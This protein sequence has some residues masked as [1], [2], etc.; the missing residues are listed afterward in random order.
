VGKIAAMP[1]KKRKSQA[2]DDSDDSFVADD[3]SPSE[4][5]FDSDVDDRNPAGGSTAVVKAKWVPDGVPRCEYGMGCTRKS[6]VHFRDEAH[7]SK[8]P[9]AQTTA[10]SSGAGSSAAGS[11][12]DACACW[13]SSELKL[14]AALFPLAGAWV[15][16]GM[17]KCKFG[18]DCVRQ[19]PLHFRTESHPA[20][21][22]KVTEYKIDASAVQLVP[23]GLPPCK[24]GAGCTR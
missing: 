16:A 11:S 6:M 5:D 15:P 2:S 21:H 7:P 1:P 14:T 18:A 24:Y 9:L 23:G 8:H 20:T 4:D 22:R 10:S 13:P 17:P 3:S 12:G 19:N